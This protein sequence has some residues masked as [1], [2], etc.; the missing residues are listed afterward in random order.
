LID[1][2][3]IQRTF[4]TGVV[5]CQ[6]D[7]SAFSEVI[8]MDTDEDESEVDDGEEEKRVK[9]RRR[10][11]LRESIR[12]GIVP[13]TQMDITVDTEIKKKPTIELKLPQ[14]LDPFRVSYF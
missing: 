9:R 5:A 8:N 1:S 3:K 7:E 10:S 13:T 11:I 6:T 4:S 12:Q 2:T 14:T